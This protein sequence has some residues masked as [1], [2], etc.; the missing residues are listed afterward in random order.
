MRA[1]LSA[2][3][4]F[5]SS[6]PNF[7]AASGA[8]RSDGQ[9]LRAIPTVSQCKHN[10]LRLHHR[11]GVVLR[12]PR[13][14]RVVALDQLPSFLFASDS[15]IAHRIHGKGQRASVW[16]PR[17]GCNDGA[18]ARADVVEA[19]YLVH[20]TVELAGNIVEL[21]DAFP[22]GEQRSAF[23][24]WR[25]CVVQY[26]CVRLVHPPVHGAG[27]WPALPLRLHCDIHAIIPLRYLHYLRLRGLDSRTCT[28]RVVLGISS[29][30]ARSVDFHWLGR[31]IDLSFLWPLFTFP[32][33]FR[34]RCGKVFRSSSHLVQP[35]LPFARRPRPTS[36]CRSIGGEVET[37]A[38]LAHARHQ[39]VMIQSILD[40][41]H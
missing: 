24:R 3:V 12:R 5:R 25:E 8:I 30:R 33:P 15:D 19:R 14:L 10:A 2:C 27:L 40:D 20:P 11:W 39:F 18:R 6:V 17:A 36:A 34:R 29:G 26:R 35:P 28:F 7:H 41:A 16:M 9:Q 21:G 1:A 38:V 23:V 13:R 32:L 37:S 22:T 4:R 31:A